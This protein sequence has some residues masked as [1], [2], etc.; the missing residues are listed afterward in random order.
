MATKR[1]TTGKLKKFVAIYLASESGN[2]MKEW[3]KLDRKSRQ[4]REKE[5]IT[6]W[7]DW[8]KKH[9]KCIIDMGNPLGSTMRADRK[10]VRKSSNAVTGYTIVKAKTHA[11]AAKLFAK[12][13]HFTMFPGEA[14]EVME[15]LEIPDAPK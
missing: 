1:K 12:H 13:P 5:A 11:A 2:M 3:E 8:A 7:H 14:V 6:A 15:C 4:Q 9:K 10:G